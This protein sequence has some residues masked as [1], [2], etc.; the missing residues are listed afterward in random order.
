VFGK[1]NKSIGLRDFREDSMV[2]L[3][4]YLSPIVVWGGIAGFLLL[5]KRAFSTKTSSGVIVL[6]A[7]IGGYSALYLWA[8]SINPHHIYAIRRFIP[9]VIPGF[10][11]LAFLGADTLLSRLKPSFYRVAIVVLPLYLAF[12]LVRAD[13][14][15]AGVAEEKGT[16]RE[17]AEI[18]SQ[19]PKDN[20]VLAWGR[21]NGWA[22]WMN[23]LLVAFDCRVAPINLETLKAPIA[24]RYWVLSQKKLKKPSLLLADAEPAVAGFEFTRIKTFTLSRSALEPTTHPLPKTVSR[25]DQKFSLYEIRFGAVSGSRRNA[26]FR[27]F[28]QSTERAGAK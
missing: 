7:V 4:R 11:L 3:G 2:N 14:L 16:F 18:A 8:P 10:I 12:F 9:T 21:V 6:L 5:F 13:R 17:L 24:L 22:E 25:S 23:P 26:N 27:G 15:I 28:F 20:T 1:W 19:L